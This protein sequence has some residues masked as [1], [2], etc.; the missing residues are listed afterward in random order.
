MLGSAAHARVPSL[1]QGFDVFV[2]MSRQE[3]FGVAVAEASAA[4]L[5]VVASNVGGLPEVV[6]DGETGFLVQSGDAE[7]LA[8]C[9]DRLLADEALR[10]RM[11]AAGREFVAR[12]FD[13]EDSV[14]QMMSIYGQLREARN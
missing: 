6:V 1:L 12:H 2:A 10:D 13:W 14:T 11:G 4:G 3:S 9:L 8:G 7:A 5:P